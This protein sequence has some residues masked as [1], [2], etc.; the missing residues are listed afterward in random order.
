VPLYVDLMLQESQSDMFAKLLDSCHL[1]V[2]IAL[3][4][5]HLLK[6]PVNLRNFLGS[7]IIYS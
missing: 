2:N 6:M 1:V 4:T 5:I 7:L 3:E